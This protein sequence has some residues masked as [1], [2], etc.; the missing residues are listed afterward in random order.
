MIQELFDKVTPYIFSFSFF[1]GFATIEAILPPDWEI[2]SS[3][4]ISNH[5]GSVYDNHIIFTTKKSIDELY[6][7]VSKIIEHNLELQAKKTL[8][9]EKKKE[10]ESIFGN[11]SLKDLNNLKIEIVKT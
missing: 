7:Y 8:F 6:D 4:E 10:L 1:N 11:T 2:L 5:Q 9:D 3:V